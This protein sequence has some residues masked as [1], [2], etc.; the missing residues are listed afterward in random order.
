MTVYNATGNNINIR[1]SSLL[2]AIPF[3][4]SVGATGDNIALDN[5]DQISLGPWHA[6]DGDADGLRISGGCSDIAISPGTSS[7]N[8]ANGFHIEGSGNNGVFL[9]G[10]I[11]RQNT[12]RGFV[13]DTATTGNYVVMNGGGTLGNG[14][15]N[16]DITGASGNVQM[17]NVMRNSGAVA[18]T[19]STGSQVTG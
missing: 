4:S 17:I 12:G 18:T 16:F 3:I 9:E 11:A 13:E 5:I 15:G 1:D 14:G 2:C 10:C 19:T 6:R 7:G 8:G